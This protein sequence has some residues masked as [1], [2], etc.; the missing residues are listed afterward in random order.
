[1]TMPG[2]FS[3]E[4]LKVNRVKALLL[5]SC[6][7]LGCADLVTWLLWRSKNV[8]NVALVVAFCS[9]PVLNNLLLIAGTN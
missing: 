1:M 9:T 6:L 3:I 5:R 4:G 7:L 2:I 8:Y